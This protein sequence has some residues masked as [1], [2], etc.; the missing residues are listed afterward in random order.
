MFRFVSVHTGAERQQVP[1][2]QRHDGLAP[3]CKPTCSACTMNL[4]AR[5]VA[6]PE[7]CSKV[8]KRFKTRPLTEQWVYQR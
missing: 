1:H 7:Q 4:N 2:K 3:I 6:K 8:Q 5:S